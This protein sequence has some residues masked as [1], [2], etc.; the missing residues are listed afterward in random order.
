V[1]GTTRDIDIRVIT[2]TAVLNLT[3]KR[4]ALNSTVIPDRTFFIRKGT[5]RDGTVLRNLVIKRTTGNGGK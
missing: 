3:I 2:V 4:A 1:K 5:A